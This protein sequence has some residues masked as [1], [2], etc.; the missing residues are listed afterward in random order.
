M[1]YSFTY[2]KGSRP[3]WVKIFTSS[4]GETYVTTLVFENTEDREKL[5]VEQTF[6]HIENLTKY[7]KD[8]ANQIFPIYLEDTAPEDGWHFKGGWSEVEWAKDE[9][10]K[11]WNWAYYN[12]DFIA[13]EAEES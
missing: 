13:E 10:L 9:A 7:I 6:E 4:S 12:D 1:N 2:D 3:R 5:T 11:W 8:R